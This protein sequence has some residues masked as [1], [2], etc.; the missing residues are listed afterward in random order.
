MTAAVDE[1][2]SPRRQQ[3]LDRHLA[4]CAACGREMATTER[5]MTA[6][7]GLPME[8]AV[9]ARLEQATMRRVR[10]E[11][12]PA[13][14]RASTWERLRGRWLTW[15]LPA[16][17]TAAVA[18]IAVVGAWRSPS[19]VAPV[20]HTEPTHAVRQAMPARPEKAPALATA[21]GETATP[22]PDLAEV[23]DL[24]V[25]L[26]ILRN[27]EKLQHFESIR[28]TT[29]DDGSTPGQQPQSNG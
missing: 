8:A 4:R 3:A 1:E 14:E 15:S 20:P 25:D 6:L 29:L 13:D 2:L 12:D 5:L 19:G 27:M 24:F 17:A 21:A 28:T 7:A 10:A 11:V 16:L 26:P 22:P 23:P 18:V 9:S